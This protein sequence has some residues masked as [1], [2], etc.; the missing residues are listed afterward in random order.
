MRQRWAVLGNVGQHQA[1]PG[2]VGKHQAESGSI[3]Q[4]GWQTLPGRALTLLS[5]SH[6]SSSYKDAFEDFKE[7][8]KKHRYYKPILIASINNCWNFR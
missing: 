2:G 4:Q 1:A 6:L 5:S 8:G 3:E 7:R